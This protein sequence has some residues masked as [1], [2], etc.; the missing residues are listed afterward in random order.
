MN[1]WYKKMKVAWNHGTPTMEDPDKKMK[2][3][4]D[5]YVQDPRTLVTPNPIF[6]GEKRRGNGMTYPENTSFRKKEDTNKIRSLPVEETLINTETPFGDAGAGDQ[7]ERFSDP[8]DKL[9][10]LDERQDPVGA[11]NMPHGRELDFYNR[12]SRKSRL[13]NINKD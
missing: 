5:P 10:K 13:R 12:L 7:T 9:R 4:L 11:F 3:R 8:I 1:N 6:G 2:N